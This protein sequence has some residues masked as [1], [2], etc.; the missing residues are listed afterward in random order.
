MVTD[1]SRAG[2]LMRTG[3][4]GGIRCVAGKARFE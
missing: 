1:E 2:Q 4:G 3:T